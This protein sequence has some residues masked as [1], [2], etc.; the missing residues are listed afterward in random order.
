MQ[1]LLAIPYPEIRSDVVAW[2]T[3]Q[4]INRAWIGVH[5]KPVTCVLIWWKK[6][7]LTALVYAAR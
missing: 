2:R 3:M 4:H 1:T 5:N 7:F 6:D